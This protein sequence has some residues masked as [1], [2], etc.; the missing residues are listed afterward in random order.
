M[1]A[2]LTGHLVFSTLHTNDAVGAV[3]RLI[4]LGVKPQI[5][6]PALTLVIAQRLVR[7][8]CPYCKIEKEI[9]ETLKE[10]IEKF[11]KDLPER[12]DRKPFKNYKIYQAGKCDKCAQ[13]GYSGRTSI[14]E[15]FVVSPEIEQLIYSNPNEIALKE[16]ARKQGMVSMQEDG[17]LKVLSGITDFKEIERVTGPIPFKDL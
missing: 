11:L 4:D 8:L 15:L 10:E 2:S 5:L 9:S 14:I 12:V 7:I 3:P 17:I 13:L 1:N 6:G 16:L